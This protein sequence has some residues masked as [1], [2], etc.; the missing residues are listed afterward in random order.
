MAMPTVS[1]TIEHGRS[2]MEE[3]FAEAM[4]TVSLT[5]EHDRSVKEERV[6]EA[7]PT[8]SL[9]IEHDRSEV[10]EQTAEEILDRRQSFKKECCCCNA[11]E[12]TWICKW[13]ADLD[14]CVCATA[15]CPP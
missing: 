9:T 15:K 13:M 5:I 12:I 10:E 1:L 7:M 4:P 8:V 11:D 6:A 3:R 14:D 2:E